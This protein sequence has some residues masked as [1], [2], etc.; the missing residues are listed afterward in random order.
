MPTPLQGQPLASIQPR[1]Q[2]LPSLAE[3]RAGLLQLEVDPRNDALV[4][5]IFGSLRTIVDHL[6]LIV[7]GQ[8]AQAQAIGKHRQDLEGKFAELIN[9]VSAVMSPP[10]DGPQAET[11]QESPTAPNPA[12]VEPAAAAPP[13]VEAPPQM[14]IAPVVRTKAGRR[15]GGGQ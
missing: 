15:A 14:T 8:R 12:P 5:Q 6:A 10:A 7:A 1:P 4:R 2:P 9:E 13:V 11:A 3:M